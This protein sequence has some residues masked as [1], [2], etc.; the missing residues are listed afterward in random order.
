[1]KQL[2][3]GL[4]DV[5]QPLLNILKRTYGEFIRG[6]DISHP[7]SYEDLVPYDVLQICFPWWD[8]FLDEVARYRE[9]TKT[10][11]IVIHSTVPIGTTESIHDAVHS[12][13]LGS[14]EH[15]EKDMQLYCKWVGGP[16]AIEAANIFN[17]AGMRARSVESSRQTELMKLMCLAKY[18]INLAFS[19]FQK[20]MCQNEGFDP[21]DFTMWDFD[22]NLGVAHNL[23]R[24]VIIPSSDYIEG[25]C[26]IPGVKLL[27]ENFPHNLLKGVLDYEI[28]IEAKTGLSKGK[29][30]V[31]GA[32]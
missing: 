18:G 19:I 30:Q 28:P 12:P 6:F 24:P 8:S 17:L 27:H 29:F 31:P 25:H 21:Q 5:G 16:R 15:M 2:I 14:H 22:Y 13:V 1:M 7:E 3:I 26:V 11:L 10:S 20:E 9:I 23:R 32:D 4:G